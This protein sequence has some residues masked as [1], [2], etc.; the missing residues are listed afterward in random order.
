MAFLFEKDEDK[1]ASAKKK[2]TVEDG[3]EEEGKLHG[4]EARKAIGEIIEQ[5]DSLSLKHAQ[6]AL[7]TL[8]L[9]VKARSAG[10][11]GR[12]G[13]VCKCTKCKCHNGKQK[14]TT[15]CNCECGDKVEA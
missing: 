2:A 8:Q 7:T 12:K 10:G 6:D 15:N 5:M 13:I 3:E 4:R 9:K 11:C 1:K 14:C